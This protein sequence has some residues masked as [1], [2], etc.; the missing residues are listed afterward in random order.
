MFVTTL[1]IIWLYE[2]WLAFCDYNWD[3][4]DNGSICMIEEQ[5]PKLLSFENLEE[6]LVQYWQ[7]TMF[8]LGGNSTV[9]LKPDIWIFQL[10]H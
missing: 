3:N 2:H 4:Q 8:L 7:V 6:G 10:Y 9:I 5:S 1:A